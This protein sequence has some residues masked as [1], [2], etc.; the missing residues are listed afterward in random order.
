M[1][2]IR[3]NIVLTRKIRF[4]LMKYSLEP[5]KN[6]NIWISLKNLLKDRRPQ[7]IYYNIVLLTCDSETGETKLCCF[8]DVF[9]SGGIV[10]GREE[11]IFLK[12]TIVKASGGSRNLWSGGGTQ[13]LLATDSA[14]VF[15][16]KWQ[17]QVLTL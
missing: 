12:V 5:L 8:G 1:V 3:E 2:N 9:R 16:P 14:V 6:V 15:Q 11:V 17:S 4:R 7:I 10:K 13:G